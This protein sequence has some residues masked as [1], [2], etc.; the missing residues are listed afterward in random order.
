MESQS[1]KK[2]IYLDYNATTPV[3]P[4]VLDAMLPYFNVHFGN[5]SSSTH[6][7]GW[8]TAE[9]VDR[10]R[11][12]LANAI[13]ALDQEIYFTSGATEGINLALKG[14]AELY[15]SKGDHIITVQTEH[16]AVLD[17]CQRLEKWG[18]RV[19]YLSVDE[20][21]LV[22]I[23]EL[24]AHISDDTI[25]VAVML[26]NNET[27]VIQ[28]LKEIADIAHR[29]GALVMSDATQAVGKIPVNVD[30][31]GIDILVM[32]GHKFYAPKGVGAIYLRRKK[33]RVRL[34]PL[35]EGGGHERG[36][37]S[38]TLNVPG[39]VGIGKAMEICVRDMKDE[40]IRVKRL[41]DQLENE[42]LSLPEV[43][44]NGALDAR[45]S[46]VSNIA[47]RY[48][49]SQGFIN[50][51]RDI[52]VATGSACTSATMEPSHVLS[53][54]GKTPDLS[55][56]SIRFSLGKYTTQQDIAYAIA[57]VKSG[58]EKLRATNPVWKLKNAH[59]A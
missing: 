22:D 40:E 33:P 21:G 35:L 17:V 59:Q 12:I 50:A 34:T 47:F 16:K 23:D 41:R 28:P 36:V 54:M 14:V 1:L 37:R 39:I 18:K 4:E 42:L 13:G 38:G 56:S 11:K 26:A 29:H 46:H 52:A 30:E 25:L 5:A 43:Y 9:A 7:Y 2:P 44:L 45:L 53:A 15:A 19:T 31:L 51:L 24:R 57:H 32:S 8:T 20:G 27:G 49:D 48:T 58:I 3:A 6:P 55:H 10:A